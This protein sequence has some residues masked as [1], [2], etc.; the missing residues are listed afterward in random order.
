MMPGRLSSV[1][2]TIDTSGKSILQAGATVAPT[3]VFAA[4]RR[5]ICWQDQRIELCRYCCERRWYSWTQAKTEWC[6]ES[7]CCGWQWAI[8]MKSFKQVPAAVEIKSSY[9]LNRWRT[10]NAASDDKKLKQLSIPIKATF[11][12]THTYPTPFKENHQ[13]IM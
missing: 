13:A 3:W 6:I 4:S 5:R 9:G 11:L 7:N 1:E 2:D 12:G 8:S 10:E